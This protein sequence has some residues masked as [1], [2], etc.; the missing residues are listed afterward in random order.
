MQTAGYIL[1]F[2]LCI[3]GLIVAQAIFVRM[4]GRTFWRAMVPQEWRFSADPADPVRMDPYMMLEEW[5]ALLFLGAFLVLP[6]IVLDFLG[7]IAI[8]H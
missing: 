4:N 8:F 7:F 3:G 6:L 5:A 2:M 1:A